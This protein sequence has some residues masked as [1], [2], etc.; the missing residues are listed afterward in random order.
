MYMHMYMQVE[1]ITDSIVVI[2]Q[3]IVILVTIVCV[4]VIM[5]TYCLVD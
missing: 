3:I 1:F 2:S 4:H 5:R